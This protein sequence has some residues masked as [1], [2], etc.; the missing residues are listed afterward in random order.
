MLSVRTVYVL[1]SLQVPTEGGN[2]CQLAWR[3]SH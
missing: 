1:G 2:F 3:G